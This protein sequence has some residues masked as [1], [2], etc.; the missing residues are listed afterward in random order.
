MN[1]LLR[2]AADVVGFVVSEAL[3]RTLDVLAP[4]P[5]RQP[6][7][8]DTTP[9]DAPVGEGLPGFYGQL[10]YPRVVEGRGLGEGERDAE[11]VDK[12]GDLWR[13]NRKLGSWQNK[14][15]QPNIC[16]TW[17]AVP[18]EDDTT[19][20]IYA[21]YTEYDGLECN[22]AS[23][24]ALRALRAAQWPYGAMYDGSKDAVAARAKKSPSAVVVAAPASGPPAEV[25]V[26][27]AD[28]EAPAPGTPSRVNPDA[29]PVLREAAKAL[30]GWTTGQ[31]MV[32][33]LLPYWRNVAHCL[34]IYADEC[35]AHQI[36]HAL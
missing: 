32:E 14:M 20:A 4:L 9:D 30:R 33:E 5:K 2:A 27:G 3:S 1:V 35:D 29:A 6:L 16:T 10:E 22:E 26:P 24:E 15:R 31:R 36:K 13:W 25:K 7:A 18:T 12:A 11:W 19:S 34:D 23:H 21:P 17:Y 8:L 28:P